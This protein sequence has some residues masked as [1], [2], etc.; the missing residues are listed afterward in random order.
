[1]EAKRGRTW[2]KN[3]TS[4]LLEV[5][6]EE[7]IQERLRSCNRQKVIWD[8]RALHLRASGFEDRLEKYVPRQ[9]KRRTTSEMVLNQMN[10]VMADFMQYQREADTAF[11][12]AE[13]ERKKREEEREGKRRKEEQDFLLKLASVLKKYKSASYDLNYFGD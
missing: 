4:V 11:L 1:M 10:S 7:N 6:G 5:W 12:K 13:M 9:K 8:E 3:E 2:E